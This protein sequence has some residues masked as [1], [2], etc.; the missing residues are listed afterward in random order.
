MYRVHSTV[1]SCILYNCMHTVYDTSV[2]YLGTYNT[3]DGILYSAAQS[4]H[5]V[6]P[7]VLYP[8]RVRYSTHTVRQ[9]SSMMIHISK[10]HI[11]MFHI[12]YKFELAATIETWPPHRIPLSFH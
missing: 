10:V 4:Y 12:Y 6:R 5:T 8:G 1:S 7:Y 2:V 11:I 3:Y 9:Y